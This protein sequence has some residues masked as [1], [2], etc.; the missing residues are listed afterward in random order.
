MPP[1]YVIRDATPHDEDFI[2]Q[3]RRR[4]HMLNAP[5]LRIAGM[6]R[7]EVDEAMDEW[8]ERNLADI[9]K[10]EKTRTYIA[11]TEEGYR[12]GYIIVS[13]GVRDDFSQLPQGFIWDIGVERVYW[14]TGV[15]QRLMER[16][17]NYVREEGGLFVSL[18]VNA[19]NGRAV[20]FYRKLGYIEEWKTM[21]K[22]LFDVEAA[23]KAAHAS[24]SETEPPSETES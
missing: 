11:E 4:N 13:Y 22:L 3:L 18:N 23:A 12:I 5:I 7:Q 21:G 20:A 19:N 17:E 15:A 6:T 16:A 1:N 24:P 14:G 10:M 8:A 9:R 2:R